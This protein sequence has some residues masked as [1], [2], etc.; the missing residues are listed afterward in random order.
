MLETL[1]SLVNVLKTWC[2]H[3]LYGSYKTGHF[4]VKSF[5]LALQHLLGFGA[6]CFNVCS[7]LWECFLIFLQDN[8][9]ILH[10]GFIFLSDSLDVVLKVIGSL[11]CKLYILYHSVTTLTVS[12]CSAVISGI[13]ATIAGVGYVIVFVKKLFILFGSGVWFLITL[14]PLMIVY[15]CKLVSA[16]IQQL[17]QETRAMFHSGLSASKLAIKDGVNFIVDVPIQSAIGI[18]V[19]LSL[20]YVLSQC[21]R[22]LARKITRNVRE[23]RRWRQRPRASVAEPLRA[24][25]VAPLPS[26]KSRQSNF[27]LEADSKVCVICQERN[28]CVLLL[29]CRHVCLCTL[30]TRELKSYGNICPICRST[31]NRTMKIYV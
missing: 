6:Q 15:I 8:V 1:V 14:L 3:I 24:P 7:I 4:L 27:D 28:K 11:C 21:Y 30:C 29:P 12:V 22:L 25:Q 2:F 23:L 26:P 20:L 19:G 17:V 9:Q 18:A 16:F 10:Q 31:I 5:G 13:T